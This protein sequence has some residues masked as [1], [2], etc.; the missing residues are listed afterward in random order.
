MNEPGEKD[1]HG[2]KLRYDNPVDL[3][4]KEFSFFHVNLS[5]R[6][7]G[8]LI[9]RLEYLRENPDLLDNPAANYSLDRTAR[10]GATKGTA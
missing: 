6:F 8:S 7:L 9:G 3:A 10:T 2:Y 5:L 4:M 1:W